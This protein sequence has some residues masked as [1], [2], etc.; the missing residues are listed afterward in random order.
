MTLSPSDVALLR[1]CLCTNDDAI[2]AFRDWKR[3]ERPEEVH[4]EAH[5]RL[6]P[7][8]YANLSGLGF[9][10][11]LMVKLKNARMRSWGEAQ[12]RTRHAEEVL[13]AFAEAHVPALVTKGMALASCYYANAALRPMADMDMVVQPSDIVRAQ[14]ILA[15]LGWSG[16][17]IASQGDTVMRDRLMRRHAIAYRKDGA[18]DLDLHLMPMHECYD[19]RLRDWFW[20]AAEP[21]AIGRAE[22]LRPGPEHLLVHVI[23]HGM[24]PNEFN[25]L[26]WIA[27]ATMIL[28]ERSDTIDWEIVY[29]YASKARVIRRLY[30]GFEELECVFGKAVTPERPRMHVSYLERLELRGFETWRGTKNFGA[31]TTSIRWAVRLR[32]LFSDIVFCSDVW[33]AFFARKVS[34]LMCA[35]DS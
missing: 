23:T 12:K 24:R 11:P 26:R 19:T 5:F 7:L 25:P 15:D 34:R 28:R 30:L 1:A 20:Q 27:D 22:C 35:R 31:S 33:R 21:A 32:L 10:D 9:D 17:D 18:A 4:N 8:L 16:E 13:S 14:A 29:R 3:L 2:S 6:F